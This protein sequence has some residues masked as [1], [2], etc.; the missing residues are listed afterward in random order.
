MTS[1]NT[2]EGSE[3]M[4]SG[5]SALLD[6]ISLELKSL[7]IGGCEVILVD[8][9]DQRDVKCDRCQI[10]SRGLSIVSTTFLSFIPVAC[11]M[12]S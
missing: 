7:S 8:V 10:I 11:P 2:L 1:V 4:M 3:S 9:L 12:Y 5:W 6:A